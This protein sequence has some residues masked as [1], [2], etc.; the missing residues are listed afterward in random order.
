MD[1]NYDFEELLNT[2]GDSVAYC[3]DSVAYWD[4]LSHK[5]SW[6]QAIFLDTTPILVHTYE[7]IGIIMWLDLQ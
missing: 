6:N 2:D 1:Y 5:G 7:L 4:S 3:G